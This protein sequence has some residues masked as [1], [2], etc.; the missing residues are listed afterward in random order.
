MINLYNE[1][2]ECCACGACANICP[3]NA[4]LMST[5]DMGFYYPKIDNKKCIKCGL[6]KKVCAFQNMNVE[7]EEPILSY[8]A[9]HRDIRLLQSSS[10]GG[11]FAA[12]SSIIL[13]RNGVVFGC[14]YNDIM[15]A[16]HVCINNKSDLEKIHGSKYVESN[17]KDNYKKTKEYLKKGK[18]VLFTGTPCQIAGLKAYLGND[19]Y[20]LVTIDLICH[21]V[22][23]SEFF[24]DY[25]RHLEQEMH[26]DIIDFKFRDKSK[27]WGILGKVKYKNGNS[28][29]EK[30]IF[31]IF[32]SYITY[33]LKGDIYRD[34]CY[35]CKYAGGRRQGD[36]TMGDY[37]GIDDNY[38]E[39]YAKNGVS[40]LLVN[41][42]KAVDFLEELQSHMILH[43]TSY[44]NAS[45][46]NR[47]LVQPVRI[48]KFRETIFETWRKGG[49]KAVDDLYCR[50]NRINF[51]LFKI[52]KLIPNTIK[53]LIKKVKY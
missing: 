27:G 45:I 10:S 21:G 52:K 3:K 35:T 36:F 37:W 7:F 15:Q 1:K 23:S 14:A 18:W 20:N 19:Y 32:S 17:L 16:E 44:S 8:A 25:I 50:S 48:S 2:K 49:Y 29:C 47:Q 9:Q 46:Q 51:L 30:I 4:I 39:I 33:F 53:R 42:K 43:E 28:V 6:C 13:N 26:S 38:E 31:P 12:I 34:S 24:R 22:P 40:I 11:V 41:T 5:D